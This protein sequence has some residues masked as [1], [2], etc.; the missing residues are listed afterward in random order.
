MFGNDRLR[1]IRRKLRDSESRW[2][3]ATEWR[4]SAWISQTSR[5]L[6]EIQCLWN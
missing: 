3:R 5:P 2:F 1:T 4:V 6:F